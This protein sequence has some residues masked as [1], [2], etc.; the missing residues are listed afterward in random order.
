MN[1]NP[2]FPTGKDDDALQPLR[3]GKMVQPVSPDMQNANAAADIIR[4]KL[5]A[6]YADEPNA[7]QEV[8]ETKATVQPLS[9]HQIFMQKLSSSGQSLA[10]I[11]T[12]W[13]NYYVALPEHEKHEVWQEFYALSSQGSHYAHYTQTH[14]HPAPAPTSHVIPKYWAK[15]DE[16][17][18]LLGLPTWEEQLLGARERREQ[19]GRGPQQPSTRGALG[20]GRLPTCA[21]KSCAA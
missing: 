5:S 9:K 1:T 20:R 12:A 17:R 19:W 4:T 15:K 3:H 11:Q 14:Q 21:V 18:R 16:E 8:A 7:A 6:I 10:H 2:L 13:H